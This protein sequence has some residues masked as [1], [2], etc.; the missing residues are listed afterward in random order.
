M[1]ANFYVHV[2]S[3]IEAIPKCP[4]FCYLPLN[5]GIINFGSLG[6][7]TF[8]LTAPCDGDAGGKLRTLSGGSRTVTLGSCPL[9]F[10][11]LCANLSHLLIIA[12][13]WLFAL[14]ASSISPSI[15]S[16]EH[17]FKI[18]SSSPFNTSSFSSNEVYKLRTQRYTESS[19]LSPPNSPFNS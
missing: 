18:S 8:R 17:T 12:S 4:K 6:L 2:Y 10:C 13:T 19:L 5:L 1:E 7:T 9:V 11:F 16:V 14:S 15:S 3:P